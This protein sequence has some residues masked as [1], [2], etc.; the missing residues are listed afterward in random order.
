[1]ALRYSTA[2]LALSLAAAPLAA[3]SISPDT[4]Q[5][6]TVVETYL[7]GLKFNDVPSFRRAF[8]PDAKL[9]FV[10]RDGQLGQLSQEDWYAGF[11]KTAGQ[12]EK[13][14]LRI[15]ALEVTRDVASVKVVEDYPGSR[16]TDYLSLV[17]FN[18]EWRI[19]N[20]IF[21]AEKRP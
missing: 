18:G 14:D 9:F 16:Y 10:R 2:L 11:A 17:R 7:H 6:R 15:A 5:V 1:M 3:Q 13:G 21:T 19:V 12:E 8:W 20:K 4:T